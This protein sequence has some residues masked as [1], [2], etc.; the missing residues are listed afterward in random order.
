[1]HALVCNREAFFHIDRLLKNNPEFMKKALEGR[2]NCASELGPELLK[3][4]KFLADLIE[5]D[6]AIFRYLPKQAESVLA[7]KH[8]ALAAGKK[9]PFAA[10]NIS[11]RLLDDTE[12]MLELVEINPLTFEFASKRLR[13]DKELAL[14]VVKKDGLML[15]YAS[16]V[17]QDD[18]EV[19]TAAIMQEGRALE[20]AS[21]RLQENSLFVATSI[22]NSLYAIYY[23][24]PKLENDT[25]F[26]KA[27][28]QIETNKN[29]KL[30]FPVNLKRKEKGNK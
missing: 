4:E 1:M 13:N 17:L 24:S 21:H 8:I 27:L 28:R 25:D 22:E 10:E 11:P 18:T 19:A 29:V 5:R 9:N 26:M 30:D 12:F 3:D 6:L 23:A 15:Q 20:F 14:A 2:P 7:N 16:T